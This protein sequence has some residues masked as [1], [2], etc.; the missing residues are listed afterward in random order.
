MEEVYVV[1]DLKDV[2]EM[3]KVPLS[4]RITAGSTYELIEQGAAL[5]PDAVAITFLR[6]GESYDQPVEIPYRE[7]I[8]KIRQTANMFADLGL[9]P[10]DVVTY[11]LPSLP[12]THYVLWG[13]E[14][15]GI[16]NPINPLLEAETIKDICQAAGTKILVALGETPGIDIWEKVE[17]IRK[18][19]PTL[20]CVVRVMGPSDEAEGIYGF[21][22]KV[23]TYAAD[24]LT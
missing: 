5:D 16:A 23:E 14:T 21:E 19:L 4:E 10:K 11:L 12:Q 18:D 3:E 22:E 17:A 8:G 6:D 2:E 7:L 1:R 15:A 24:R 9:G 13:G 20:K